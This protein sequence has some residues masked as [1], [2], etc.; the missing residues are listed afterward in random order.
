MK[1]WYLWLVLALF[2]AIGGVV[3]YFDGRSIIA[4]V[5]QVSIAIILAFIQLL[6]ER[7]EEKGKKAFNYIAMVLA[8]IL[9]IWIIAM[10]VDMFI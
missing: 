3:N 5:I 10:I 6:C 7:K 8:I 2:F 1:K 4:Q 9:G